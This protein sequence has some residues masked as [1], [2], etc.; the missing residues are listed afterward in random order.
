PV[1]GGFIRVAYIGD[2]ALQLGAG[3]A[4][5]AAAAIQSFARLFGA[6][7]DLLAN[8]ADAVL[9][10]RARPMDRI[11]GT[12]DTSFGCRSDPADALAKL[13]LGLGTGPWREEERRAGPDQRAPEECAKTT[14]AL[15][16]HDVWQIVGIAHH[17]DP[18]TRLHAE[19][20]LHAE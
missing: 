9:E 16:D 5:G 2:P 8:G 12:L 4:R 11:A 7:V 17:T 19:V 6:D 10:A 18:F 13:L 15:L 1:E 14:T 20:L 3:V